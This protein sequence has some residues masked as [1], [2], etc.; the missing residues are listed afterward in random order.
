M[1]LKFIY[2]MFGPLISIQLH[3]VIM[4]KKIFIHIWLKN[5]ISIQKKII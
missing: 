2:K 5:L 3:L 1:Y 4:V